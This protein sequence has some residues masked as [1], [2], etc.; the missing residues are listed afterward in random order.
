MIYS[1]KLPANG[2][3]NATLAQCKLY[4][5]LLEVSYRDSGSSS[6]QENPTQTFF[7]MI[8]N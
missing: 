3:R 8:I 6:I 2:Y 7:E 4:I 5:T 1:I